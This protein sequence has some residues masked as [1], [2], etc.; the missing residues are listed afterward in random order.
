MSR[1]FPPGPLSAW[2]VV[3]YDAP[4]H[5]TTRT[6][7]ERAE[8]LARLGIGGLAWDYREEHAEQ[9]PA[10][11][12]ALAA[13]GI[14]LTA[15]W[16]NAGD[17]GRAGIDPLA[18]AAIEE[19]AA[20][21][22]TPQLWA[23]PEFGPPGPGPVLKPQNQAAHAS[24]VADRLEPLALLAAEHGMTVALYNHLGWAGEPEN[25][26]A[27]AESL[28]ARGL[29]AVGLVYV[30]H[31]GHAHLDRFAAMWSR[32][33]HRVVALTLNGMD[34]GE[35][36]GG[37]KILPYGHGERDVALARIIAASGWYGPTAVIGHTMDDVEARL[38]DDVEGLAWV[39]AVVADEGDAAQAPPPA[40]IPAPV[41]P[42]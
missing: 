37:R 30:Q 9:F 28:E 38:A 7:E 22:L 3:P 11:L 26:I 33:K 1:E 31:H 2:C 14:E 36:W 17:P 32:I 8:M 20:R 15:V 24:A 42:H 21:G 13:H 34:P 6:P 39:A 23:C 27:V 35:H 41:W 10:Q 19:A 29:P 16:V 5:G 12:D 40:R 25:L 4:P 18:V